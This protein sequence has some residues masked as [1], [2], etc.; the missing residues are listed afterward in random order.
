MTILILVA[1]VNAAYDSQTKKA[2]FHLKEGT[3]STMPIFS[4]N[5]VGS[6]CDI[7]GGKEFV[8]LTWIWSPT[9]KEYVLFGLGTES[10][11]GYRND[12]NNGYY[13]TI[14]GGMF[15]Y[16]VKDCDIWINDYSA[17]GP[18]NSKIAPGWQFI[19]KAPWM[20]KKG[21]DVFGNCT[22]QKFN[23]W[24]ANSQNWMC[25]PS[26]TSPDVLRNAF[27]SA[28]VGEVFLIRFVNEC[29]LNIGFADMLPT[30]PPLE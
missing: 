20:Q 2:T 27:N 29:N 21:F 7:F 14:Y 3:W 17:I 18:M 5:N 28:E 12:F 4:G 13:Y 24:D 19:A 25:K 30:P 1:S 10:S 16:V 6:D 26:E 23:K 11:E 9:L 15:I 22:I 8:G